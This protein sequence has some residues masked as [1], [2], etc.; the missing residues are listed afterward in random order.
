M[1]ARRWLLCALIFIITIAPSSW[2]QSVSPKQVAATDQLKMV[3]IL[4][5]HGVRS[6]LNLPA[7]EGSWPQNQQ[8]W[9]VDCCGDLTPSGEQLVRQMGAYY[10][11]YYA[12]KDKK[13]LPEDCP[14]KEVYIWADNE[15][16]TIQTGR[17]LA[18]GL[19]GHSPGCNISV[20]SQPYEPSACTLSNDKT[21]QRKASTDPLFHPK[22]IPEPAQMQAIADDI[23]RRYTDL[24][25]RYRKP[26]DALQNTLCPTKNCLLAVDQPAS[27]SVA[28]KKLNWSGRFSTG[29]NASEIFLL[30]YGHGMPCA[31]VGWGKVAFNQPD[32]SQG[33]SFRDM[34]EIHTAYFQET[35][36]APYIA[37]IQGTPLLNAIAERL[38]QAMQPSPAA[39]KLVI[40]AGHDTNIANV[41]AML[42]IC[43]KLPDLPEND[44]PPA[45]ALV[46]ELYRN[47][48][49]GKYSLH[50]RYVYQMLGQLRT[51]ADLTLERPPKW[52]EVAVPRCKGNCNLE[53]FNHLAANPVSE[54]QACT[55]RGPK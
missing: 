6:P 23:N 28:D 33:Q 41:A 32:C 38:N 29:S 14:E 11:L 53:T 22:S 13:L 25:E 40:F 35:Q 27:Y 19:A 2:A 18:Q 34:Q 4:T 51:K 15:E 16:R 52:I 3:V 9:S 47:S 49:T 30:E 5:R 24:V 17:E 10:H 20:N 31:K 26:L 48:M 7:A 37:K 8:D 55:A 44:T 21:C 12:S 50:I 54:P 43:W 45:G 39:Q 1:L 36:R 46:F 42:G